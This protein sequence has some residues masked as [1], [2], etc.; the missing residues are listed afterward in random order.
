MI[1]LC[2][3][4]ITLLKKGLNDTFLDSGAGIGT[5]WIGTIPLLRID[6]IFASKELD[7]TG[8]IKLKNN[9]SDHYPVKASFNLSAS[10]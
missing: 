10:K 4:H 5:T 9:L 6:Y 8:L 1:L 3:T 7:N 2:H